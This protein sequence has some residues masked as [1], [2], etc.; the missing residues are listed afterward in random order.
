MVLQGPVG[1]NADPTITNCEFLVKHN[2]GGKVGFYRNTGIT[3][4]SA[5]II[6][7]GADD[8]TTA[9]YI[10]GIVNNSV[11]QTPGI[12]RQML[13]NSTADITSDA[14]TNSLRFTVAANGQ[15]SVARQAGTATWDVS[16][17]LIWF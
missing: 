13:N 16:L 8:V 10:L 12:N 7:D 5:I 6:P 2:N 14:G 3:G 9:V 15:V 1:I 4:S 11:P 17:L